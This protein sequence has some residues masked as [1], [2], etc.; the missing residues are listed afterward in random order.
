MYYFELIYNS[1]KK[2]VT[3]QYTHISTSYEEILDLFNLHVD[4]AYG[5]LGTV[6]HDRH[7]G[8]A[9]RHEGEGAG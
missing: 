3:I 9:V 4:H 7:A 5:C 2:K 8:Y 1:N 6:V